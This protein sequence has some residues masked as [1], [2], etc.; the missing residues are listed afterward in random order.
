[1]YMLLEQVT[2]S[3]EDRIATYQAPCYS[4]NSLFFPLK[5]LLILLFAK[6]HLGAVRD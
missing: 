2:F 4:Y 5:S 1:M 3:Y 6:Y